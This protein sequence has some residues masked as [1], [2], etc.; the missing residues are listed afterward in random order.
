MISSTI[1]ELAAERQTIAGALA[2]AGLA[3]R[4][5]FELHATAAGEPPEARYLDVARSCDLYV[6]IVAWER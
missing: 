6:I 1:G 4:W 3:E 2:V 5:L